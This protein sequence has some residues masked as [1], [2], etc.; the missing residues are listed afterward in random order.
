[1]MRGSTHICF[2]IN[3]H[4]GHDIVEFHVSLP[5]IATTFDGFDSLLQII[6]AYG[7]TVYRRLGYKS[8]G[9]TRNERLRYVSEV[10][11]V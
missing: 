1:M 10:A 2:G 11:W 9:G 7:A 3:F 5:N 4:F 8:D 6:L